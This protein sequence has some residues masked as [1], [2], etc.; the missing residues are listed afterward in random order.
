M[1]TGA[2]TEVRG[3]GAVQICPSGS[4]FGLER[5][6]THQ[7]PWGT[8]PALGPTGCDERVRERLTDRGWKSREGGHRSTIDS[9]RRCDTT[10]P[11]ITVDEHR[12]TSALTLRCTP[13]F[14]GRDAET[15][16]QHRQQRFTALDI[17]LDRNPVEGE[18]QARQ[19]N[20][21]PQPQVRCALGLL[22]WKPEPCRPSR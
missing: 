18:R 21:C 16:A 6:E 13:V 1:P 3:E 19:L 15:L 2:A 22:T 17:D 14:H 12:A 10:D 7:D 8:E 5:G 20:D 11:S 9:Q 4:T